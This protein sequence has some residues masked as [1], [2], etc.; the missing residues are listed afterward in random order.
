MLKLHR[1]PNPATSSPAAPRLPLLTGHQIQVLS[2]DHTAEYVF[3]AARDAA[4]GVRT[5]RAVC[6]CGKPTQPAR[7]MDTAIR[8][9]GNHRAAIF[10]AARVRLADLDAHA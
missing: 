10:T 8:D 1:R 4:A 7:S 6:A 3:E 2:H 9:Q 5:W